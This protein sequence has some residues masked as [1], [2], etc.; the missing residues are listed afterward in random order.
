VFEKIGIDFRG[1][2]LQ[3]RQMNPDDK[4][5][6]LAVLALCFFAI[7]A[8]VGLFMARPLSLYGFIVGAG[9]ML[10]GVGVAVG[11]YYNLRK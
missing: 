9:C 6:L 11:A 7:L 4:Q 1:K 5:F 3:H 8:S 2:N 10:F